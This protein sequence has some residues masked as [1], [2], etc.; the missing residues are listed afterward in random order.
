MAE[1][2]FE[3]HISSEPA[4][5]GLKVWLVERTFGKMRVAESMQLVFKEIDETTFDVP[6]T[7]TLPDHFANDFLRAM[8]EALD[9]RGIKVENEHKVHGQLEATKYHLEDSRTL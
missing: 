1:S 9:K 8:A 4:F 3:V 2:K 6:A 5:Y 7:L